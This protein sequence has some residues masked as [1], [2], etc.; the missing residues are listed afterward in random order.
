MLVKA[1]SYLELSRA[2]MM[3]LFP[4]IVR[5]SHQRCFVRE[6]VLRNFAKFTGKHLC[7]SVFFNK[8]AGL[9]VNGFQ[10]LSQKASS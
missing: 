6:G 8:V 10:L 9:I 4:V 5:S 2:S 7:Q 1:E 3:G